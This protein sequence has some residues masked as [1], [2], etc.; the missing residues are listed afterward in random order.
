MA[1]TPAPEILASALRFPAGCLKIPGGCLHC[2]LNNSGLE[3]PSPAGKS[4]IGN[5]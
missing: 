5:L 3:A 2:L 1:L 4:G